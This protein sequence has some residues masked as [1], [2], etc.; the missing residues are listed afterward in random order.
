MEESL[1][2]TGEGDEEGGEGRGGRV[3]GGVPPGS[4]GE[5]CRS[6]KVVEFKGEIRREAPNL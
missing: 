4:L 6:N 1:G 2:F 3:G 5:L